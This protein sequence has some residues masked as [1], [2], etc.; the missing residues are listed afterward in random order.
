MAGK[1]GSLVMNVLMR[2]A[3]F[4]R[5][6][7]QMRGKVTALT[8][9]TNKLGAAVGGI[10]TG[11]LALAPFAV[12]A[13][14]VALT[15][16]FEGLNQAMTRSLAIMGDVSDMMR[17]DMRRAAITM[18]KTTQFSATQAAE[19]YFFLASAGKTAEQSIALL[20][21]V[22]AF[23]QA[24]NFDLALATDLLTDAQ[25]AL[26]LTSKD[27]EQDMKNLV[28]VS[29][30]LVKA[31][32][33]ANASVQQFSE[34]LTNKAGAAMRRLGI[35]IEEGI[36]VLAVFADQG[37]KGADAGTAFA[38]V[39]RDLTTKAIENKKAFAKAGIEVFD[40]AGEL[41]NFGDI[42]TDLTASLSKL[43]DREQKATLIRLGFTNKSIAA[44]SSLLGFEESIKRVEAEQRALGITTDDVAANSLTPMQEA[45]DEM[46][47]S[48][49]QF[50]ETSGPA[51]NNVLLDFIKLGTQAL[52]LPGEIAN[53]FDELE[54]DTGLD[55]RPG[56]KLPTQEPD[57]T[58]QERNRELRK[59]I[60]L[61]RGF[62]EQEFLVADQERTRQRKFGK[63]AADVLSRNLRRRDNLLQQ[64]TRQNEA[65]VK[66]S[67]EAM[68]LST[69]ELLTREFAEKEAAKA[70]KKLAKEKIKDLETGKR[71]REDTLTVVEK[72]R[73]EL[74]EIDRLEKAGVLAVG[75]RGRAR[76]AAFSRRDA[77]DAALLAEVSARMAEEEATPGLIRGRA[78]APESLERG[79]RA[80]FIKS[81]ELKRAN[82]EATRDGTRDAILERIAVSVEATAASERKS[83]EEFKRIGVGG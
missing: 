58:D 23:A 50:A 35:D 4:D 32:T 61:R 14:V 68:K 53:A 28:R 19:A 74:E 51:V 29:D 20:P 49:T 15:R 54:R 65:R 9:V 70:E 79:S 67:V 7:K 64:E 59:R 13:G 25:S 16:R 44:T 72:F 81:E 3:Q 76:R 37:V 38:I 42:V 45:M 41:R 12:V 6:S 60:S 71:L 21:K 26:G 2:T 48:W 47:G 83:A 75:V 66:A 57:K 62:S 39:L 17:R 55:F 69:E 78:A 34:A 33:Q 43:S 52:N 80:A 10:A 31:N 73:K 27:I 40:E 82:D 24:G 22:A 36:A 11:F 30:A 8:A 5:K 77:D 18:G 46:S 63:E 56:L 1:V